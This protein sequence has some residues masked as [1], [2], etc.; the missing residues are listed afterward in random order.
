MQQLYAGERGA[1][2]YPSQVV[3]AFFKVMRTIESAKDE[4]DLRAM[5]HL[6]FE[7]LKGKRRHQRSLVLHGSFRL[8]LQLIED[9]DGTYLLIEEIVDYHRG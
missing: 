8:I 4:Q 2:R 1:Q 7:R 5:K 3:D 9:E 6:R